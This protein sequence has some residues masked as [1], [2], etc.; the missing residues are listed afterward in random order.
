[1]TGRRE[2][3]GKIGVFCEGLQTQTAGFIDRILPN[4]ANGTRDNSDTVPAV[5]SA[6]IKIKPAGIFQSLATRD[7]RPQIPNFSVT[8]HCADALIGKR[9]E[10]TRER[11]ALALRV[12]IDKNHNSIMRGGESALESACFAAIFL[13]EQ[14]NT[15]FV[16]RY[17]LNLRSGLIGRAIVDDDYFYFAPV[18]CGKERPQTFRY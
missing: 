8:R 9:L 10:Q 15:R 7:E 16:F 17:A 2:R 18:V 3:K 1:M 5:V 14:T 4:G 6:P 13:S 12:G 11:V